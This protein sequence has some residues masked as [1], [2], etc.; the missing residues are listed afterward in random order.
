MYTYMS[1]TVYTVYN[2]TLKHVRSEYCIWEL[3][4]SEGL[5][6]MTIFHSTDEAPPP[7]PL[8]ESSEDDYIMMTS[9]PPPLVTAHNSKRV[10]GMSVEGMVLHTLRTLE[11]GMHYIIIAACNDKV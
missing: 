10:M 5:Y 4:R 11:V 8:G 1:T 2:F 7:T 9:A 6:L 3:K